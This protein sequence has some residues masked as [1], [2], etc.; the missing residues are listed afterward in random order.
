MPIVTC[1]QCGE[2]VL[3]PDA[4]TPEMCVDCKTDLI[5]E[6]NKIDRN[7]DRYT[8]KGKIKNRLHDIPIE[9]VPQPVLLQIEEVASEIENRQHLLGRMEELKVIGDK[10]IRDIDLSYGEEDRGKVVLKRRYR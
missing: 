5:R 1:V 4:D 9:A 6:I 2:S 3:K 7:D 10:E 8:K